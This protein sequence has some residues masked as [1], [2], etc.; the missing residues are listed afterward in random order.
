MKTKFIVSL[1][2]CLFI[3]AACKR[4]AETGVTEKNYILK[5]QSTLDSL[6]KNYG[7]PE[8]NLLREIYPFDEKYQASYLASEEKNKVPN[9]YSYLW[10]YSGTLSAV[11]VLLETTCSSKYR[12]LLSNQVLPGLEEYLDVSRMTTAYASYINSAPASDRFYDDNVWIGIDFTDLYRTTG[13]ERYLKKAQLLWRFIQ[14]GT[15]DKL[16]GGIYWCEQKKES[17]NT[18]SNA[19]GSVFAFKLFEVTRDSTYY[20]QGKSLYE[21]TKKNLQD[22]QDYLYFDHIKMDS[23]IG[24]TKY[25]YNSGQMMQSAAL[26]YKLTKNPVYLTEAQ[27]LA[28]ACYQYF[29]QDFIGK[30]GKEFKLIKKGNTWFTAVMLRGFIELYYQDNNSVYLDA[31]S[32]NLDYAWQYARDEKGLFQ[33]DFSGET[34]DAQKWLLTQAAMVEMYGRMAGIK[35]KE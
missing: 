7:I 8:T 17:K 20:H 13:K 4:P 22:P 21:W 11:N 26:L 28:K 2:L 14:S 10:P 24:K 34:R 29:F 27:N 6:S 35:L 12:Q 32:Q 33:T 3:L 23:T 9:P 19:P 25:S 1:C 18:C 30:N 15:D 5:A 16:G 31:F